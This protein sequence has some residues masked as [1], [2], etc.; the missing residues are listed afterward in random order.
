MIE[1]SADKKT[2]QR[3]FALA[4]RDALSPSEREAASLKLA[5]FALPIPHRAIVS[6]YSPI[7]S[8]IDPRPLMRKLAAEGATLA[9]PVV[10]GRAQ[11]LIFRK[12]VP[13]DALVLAGYGLSEPDENA[14]Q[15]TPDV[16]LV[17]LA[18]FDSTGHRLG[19]GAGHYD[20]TI[21]ALRTQRP[22]T[23]IGL[24]FAAQETENI[25][26][27]ELDQRLDMVLTERGLIQFGA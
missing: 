4:R 7:R 17:P 8:E 11:A 25:A 12:W 21:A 23:T 6:G 26:F 22:L 16:L 10:T 15:V 27:G 2:D 13:G 18:A 24:A 14:E 20:R 9:L 1:I 3:R 5:S 19:Y